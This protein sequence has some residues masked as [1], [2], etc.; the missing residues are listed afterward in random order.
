MLSASLTRMMAR[1]RGAGQIFREEA[2]ASEYVCVETAD[3]IMAPHLLERGLLTIDVAA[4]YLGR[5]PPVGYSMNAFWTR[6]GPAFQADIQGFHVDTDDD[7]F[8]AMF[9]Y[10]TDVLDDDCGPHDLEGPDSIVRTMRGPAGTAFL[11]DTRL[12][13][14]GRKPQRGERGIAWFRWGVSDR[15]PANVWDKIE[16]VAA[17]RMGQRYPQDSRLREAVKLLVR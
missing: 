2:A 14:R 12:R 13:H 16:P 5:D 6:P 7:R 17:E 1:A 4:A 15:P 10:L 9:V 3:A 11:A 8:L